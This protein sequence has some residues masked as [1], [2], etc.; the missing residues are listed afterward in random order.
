M[1]PEQRKHFEYVRDEMHGEQAQKQEA[2]DRKA[3]NAR[4]LGLDYEPEQIRLECVKC[5][6]VYAEGIPPQTAQKQEPVGRFSKFTDGVWRE[7]T[8]TSA[9]QPLYA[10]PP[11]PQPLTDESVQLRGEIGVLVGLLGAAL[12]VIE[13]V[14]G[15]DSAECQMLMELQ[16]KIT[17]AIR[18]ASGIEGEA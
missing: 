1:T 16:N 18:G 5:G 17:Y 13:T 6:T 9:G 14:D 2:L 12:Q 15:D 7:V 10:A 4:E 3:E 11:Q 8:A